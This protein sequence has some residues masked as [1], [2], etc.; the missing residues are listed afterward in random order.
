VFVYIMYC[1]VACI[2]ICAIALGESAG[3]M[4]A[5]QFRVAEARGVEAVVAAMTRFSSQTTVQLSALLCFIPLA[6]ENIMMQASPAAAAAAACVPVAKWAACHALLC[7]KAVHHIGPPCF[8][9][10][11]Q[12]TQLVLCLAI[13]KPLCT[14]CLRQCKYCGLYLMS[15]SK[16]S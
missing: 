7:A 15:W 11:Q 6:L 14:A 3:I 5:N 4:Q 10:A 8:H 12:L 9:E 13:D 2:H 1:S 16:W